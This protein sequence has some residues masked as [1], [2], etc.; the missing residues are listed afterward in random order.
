M[1]EIAK[2]PDKTGNCWDKTA[3]NGLEKY[4]I[5]GKNEPNKK[6]FQSETRKVATLL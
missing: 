5:L 2:K 1:R 6:L 3:K 4:F